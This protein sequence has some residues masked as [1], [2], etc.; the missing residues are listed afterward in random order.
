MYLLPVTSY[1][2]IYLFNIIIIH[3]MHLLQWYVCSGCIPKF[4]VFWLLIP[5]QE[6]GY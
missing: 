3:L 4:S 2:F 5:I 6:R 1:L